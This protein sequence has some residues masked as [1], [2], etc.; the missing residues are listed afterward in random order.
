MQRYW[1]TL[2]EFQRENFEI[3]V[4]KSWED[5]HPGDCF[6]D[7]CFNIKEICEEIDR[8]DLDWFMLRVR[9]LFEGVEL[10]EE[11]VGGFLYKDAREVLT[12]GTAEDM[13]WTAIDAAKGRARELADKMTQLVQEL[14]PA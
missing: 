3:H 1:D 5:L 12:D 7:T 8:G 11:Y 13:I 9:V 14:E 2:A 10:A 4:E 6:D